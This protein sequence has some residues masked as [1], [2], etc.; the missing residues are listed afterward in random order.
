MHPKP[1]A[2]GVQILP[3]D[4]NISQVRWRG[5]RDTMRVGF[6]SV[7]H[8]SGHTRER[9][10]AARKDK[11]FQDFADFLNRVQPEEPE[12]KSLVHANAFTSLCPGDS[13]ADLL[14]EFCRF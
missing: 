8:L 1:D 14:W 6:L 12:V 5:N 11:P 3:P 2:W 13:Q 9:I 4:V 10:I 7:K